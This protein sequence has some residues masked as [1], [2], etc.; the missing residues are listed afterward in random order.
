M[1]IPSSITVLK[2]LKI[3]LEWLKMN[4]FIEED[5]FGHLWKVLSH[6]YTGCQ[7]KNYTRFNFW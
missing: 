7:R 4:F 6:L 1:K 3:C 5:L 2:F